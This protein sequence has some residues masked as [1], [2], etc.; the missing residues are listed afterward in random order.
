MI[1][2]RILIGGGAAMAV[3]A[4][5]AEMMSLSP[6]TV[7]NGLAG[8][9][10]QQRWTEAYGDDPRQGV[11]VYAPADIKAA[12]MVVFFYGG[13]WQE[14]ERVDYRFVGSALAGRGF[15]TAIPDYRLYP[16]VLYPDFLKDSARAVRWARDNAARF[17]G[18]PERLVV[19]GHSAGAHI[20]AMLTLDRE[21]LAAEGMEAHRDLSGMVGLAGP[22]EFLPLVDD[23]LKIIFGP[24][25]GRAV[26]QPINHVDGHAPPLLLLTGG[27]DR[28]V[29]P[30]NSTRLA[31]KVRAMGGV[32]E[33]KDYPKLDHRTLV[34]ALAPVLR[35][36]GPVLPDV[37]GF[38]QRVAVRDHAGS[39]A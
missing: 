37:A 36:L 29:D 16:Q 15:V 7:L 24:E 6:L 9:P 21:W 33:R 2:R 31:A 34:G 27:Q 22:Y 39:P 5:G 30:A 23:T 38:I 26:S 12:P 20:A 14:G 18:D 11:D 19:M 32:A 4:T 3:G 13:S 35:P 25:A 10:R 1:S 8:L 28:T 17:G